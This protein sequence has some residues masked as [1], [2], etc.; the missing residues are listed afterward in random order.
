MGETDLMKRRLWF[1]VFALILSGAGFYCKKTTAGIWKGRLVAASPCDHFVV[2][3]LSG[4]VADSAILTKAWTDSATDSSYTNVFR[5]SDLCT[6]AF[7]HVRVGD[8]FTFTLNGPPP[9]QTCAVCDIA[10]FFPMP[11]TSNVVTNIQVVGIN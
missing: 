1:V 5:V 9:A 2:Q 11:A 3:L 6:F 4:P 7:S 8:V 10:P